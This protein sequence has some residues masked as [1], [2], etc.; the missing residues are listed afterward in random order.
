MQCSGYKIDPVIVKRREAYR[1]LSMFVSCVVCARDRRKI[2]ATLTKRH[3]LL[4]V[5]V[6]RWIANSVW[7][8]ATARKHAMVKRIRR[9]RMIPTTK[10]SSQCISAWKRN[11]RFRSAFVRTT[12]CDEC[13][14][15]DAP[16]FCFAVDTFKAVVDCVMCQCT[17]SKGS[18]FC[19]HKMTPG[20]VIPSDTKKPGPKIC[21]R[22]DTQGSSGFWK[23][24]RS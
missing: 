5:V 12:L 18:V 7:Q 4:L 10:S 20:I 22:K 21:S 3:L 14:V 16:D 19:D 17:D 2:E 15:E 13:F 6:P 11:A 23:V 8:V 24:H 1:S 9:P